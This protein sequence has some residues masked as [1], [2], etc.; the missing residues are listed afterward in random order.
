MYYNFRKQIGMIYDDDEFEHHEIYDHDEFYVMLQAAMDY[1]GQSVM[2]LMWCSHLPLTD[3]D[4]ETLLLLCGTELFGLCQS[5][6]YTDITLWGFLHNLESISGYANDVSSFHC[7]YIEDDN[8]VLLQFYYQWKGLEI[9]AIGFIKAVAKNIYS[10][11][12]EMKIEELIQKSKRNS[13]VAS[14]SI[15]GKIYACM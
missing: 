2:L 12:V 13:Y 1:S 6:C 11:S 3:L 9:I 14:F 7:Q 5:V 15:K 8:G 10:T 4:Q